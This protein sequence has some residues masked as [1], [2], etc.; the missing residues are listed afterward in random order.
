MSEPR[1]ESQ[2]QGTNAWLRMQCGK[3]AHSRG[4]NGWRN[5]ETASST[6]DDHGYNGWKNR[7]TWNVALWI[8]NDEGLYHVARGFQ[9]LDRPYTRLARRLSNLRHV[10]GPKGHV[11]A[12]GTPDGVAWDNPALDI[13][14]LDAMIEEL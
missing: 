12:T 8:G 7:A 13:T 4:Y 2:V 11:W 14:A 3:L 1:D 6:R 5:R 10:R 9:G